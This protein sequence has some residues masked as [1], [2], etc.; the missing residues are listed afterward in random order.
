MSDI[1]LYIHI[2]F[3]KSKCLYCDFLSFSGRDAYIEQYINS[4]LSEIKAFKTAKK[5]KSIFIGGGTPSVIDKKYIGEI[6]QT[7]YSCF[8]VK[9]EAEVTIESN[10]GTVD[11][12]KLSFYRK[13][14]INRIS[15]GLQSC[16]DDILKK[17][18]RIHTFDDFKESFM[19]A[20]K[21]GFENIN[22][23]IMFSLPYQSPED[24]FDTI[25]R[26][27]SLNPEHISAYSLI[28]EEG[29]PF[30]Y[31]YEKG[32]FVMPD[33][34]TD[35]FMYHKGT[36]LLEEKGYYRYEISNYAKKDRYCRHNMVYWRRG[37]YKGFGLGAASLVDEV[38]LKNTESFEK[39][40]NGNYV[41]EREELTLADRQEEFMFLGL[42]CINGIKKEDFFRCFGMTLDSVYGKQIKELT[43]QKLI[44]Q[45]EG[46]IFLTEKGLDLANMVFVEFMQ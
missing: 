42:R 33:E 13:I 10:P 5:V 9:N 26:V 45:K 31:M 11:F 12:D 25:D 6:M 40:I 16:N 20:R 17:I 15:F 36:V 30:H 14:G 41:I 22:C 24:Y 29:T 4:L 21:A 44:K 34:Y 2:P 8:D 37:E 27:T 7:V 43:K 32:A 46:K 18:G 39:Y 28:I 35:R 1:S 38:R 23:D 3:C 19:L